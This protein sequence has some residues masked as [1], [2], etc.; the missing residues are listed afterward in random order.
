VSLE[1]ES[2][3]VVEL[4]RLPFEETLVVMA[5]DCVA[6]VVFVLVAFT[7]DEALVLTFVVALGV[8]VLFTMV[9]LPLV[10]LPLTG[11][12]PLVALV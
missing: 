5:L 7:D 10:A 6:L 1:E 9:L 8:M 11:V 3:P 4:V 2:F 12:V